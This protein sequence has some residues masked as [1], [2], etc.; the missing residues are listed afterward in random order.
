M[1][2]TIGIIGES[3]CNYQCLGGFNTSDYATDPGD[4]Q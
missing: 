4:E 3:P 2:S 1:E